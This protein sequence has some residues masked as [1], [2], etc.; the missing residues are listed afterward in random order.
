MD[1]A[2]PLR[3]LGPV[4]SAALR[5]IVLAQEEDAW[6]EDVYRQEAFEVHHSTESIVM[7]FVDIERW[8]DIV[9]KREPGWPLL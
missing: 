5:D 9:V 2:T 6:K 1:I 4:D 7:L 3:E 8:P